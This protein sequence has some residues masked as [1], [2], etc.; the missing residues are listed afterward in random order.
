MLFEYMK[1]LKLTIDAN[2]ILKVCDNRNRIKQSE[3][4]VT[5]NSDLQ[6]GIGFRGVALS[7]IITFPHFTMV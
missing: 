3:Q 2:K 6:A 5:V 4:L 1:K 7:P